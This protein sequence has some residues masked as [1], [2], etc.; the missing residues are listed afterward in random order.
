MADIQGD[1]KIGL[2]MQTKSAEQSLKS[3]RKKLH[4]GLT[5]KPLDL[6]VKNTEKTIKQLENK[7][8]KTKKKLNDLS[9]GATK[10]KQ[11]ID[12]EKE[13]DKLYAQAEK[14]KKKLDDLML[15]DIKPKSVTAM[16]RELKQVEKQIT[17]VN[18]QLD[19]AEKKESEAYDA[20]TTKYV[21]NRGLG[22]SDVAAQKAASIEFN[23]YKEAKE[24]VKALEQELNILSDKADILNSKLVE[25]QLNPQ[26]SEEF[27]KAQLEVDETNNAIDKLQLKLDKLKGN[28]QLTDEGKR[29][30]KELEEASAE[31]KKQKKHLKDIQV[32]Q[33]NVVKSEKVVA[34]GIQPITSALNKLKGMIKR[35]FVFS[36]ITSALR[37]LRNGIS[38]L[39]QKDTQLSKSLNQIKSNLVTAFA[40]IW[41]VCIP[42][43]QKLMNV[44]EVASG[45]IAKFTALITGTSLKQNQKYAQEIVDVTQTDKKTQEEIDIENQIK[46]L[47]KQNKALQKQQK[48]KEKIR[49][50]EEKA[51]QHSLASFDTISVLNQTNNDIELDALDEEIDKN[52]EI[53]DQLQEKLELLEE[54]RTG[55]DTSDRF[56]VEEVTDVGKLDFTLWE[57]LL[58]NLKQIADLFKS[59]FWK[60]FQNAD[61]TN[62]KSDILDISKSF[63]SLFSDTNVVNSAANF[64]SELIE[65]LGQIIGAVASIGV[66]IGQNLIGGIQSFLHSNLNN[67]KQDII[68]TLDVSSSILDTLGNL[69][70]AIATIFSSIGTQAGQN[71]T[72]AILSTLY[73]VGTGILTL[74]LQIGDTLLSGISQPIINNADKIKSAFEITFSAF[75]PI[76]QGVSDTVRSIFDGLSTVWKNAIAPAIN[77]VSTAFS[78][79]FGSLL[80]TFNTTIGPAFQSAFSSI[81]ASLSESFSPAISNLLSS[82]GNLASGLVQ[83]L[84]PVGSILSSL[85]DEIVSA[86]GVAVASIISLFGTILTPIINVFSTAINA[87]G[88]ILNDLGNVVKSICENNIVGAFKSAGQTIL[89]IFQGIHDTIT[90][91]LDSLV[92][93]IKNIFGNSVSSLSGYSMTAGMPNTMSLNSI[94]LQVPA[95][96]QGAVLPPNNPFLAVVSDQTQGTNIEAPA[97]LIKQMVKEANEESNVSQQPTTVREDHYYLNKTE[98]MNLT[99]KL[100]KGGEKLH[101]TELIKEV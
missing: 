58:D 70:S 63:K 35:V 55:A 97:E 15:T 94:D 52:N 53:I 98:L 28:P 49:Q 93:I 68:K 6:S 75:T 10:P 13:L 91:I 18:K 42:W 24:D 99:Y 101:G 38:Q 41:K 39:I 21:T 4:D 46:A 60:S 5:T 25:V 44:L 34:S 56:T 20:Y 80:N 86:V 26:A 37:T 100:F 30:N 33:E 57:I 12:I 62:L 69:S 47:E 61:F 78:N 27:K 67:I 16:Q 90:S 40:P 2:N 85:I 14:S 81:G 1:V 48:E 88:D 8:D 11:V 89:D 51:N 72:G 96:A 73:N 43:I 17:D 71:L 23:Q 87:I 65:V 95:L 84:S 83:L 77:V 76:I 45:Y 19:V 59:G 32:E 64:S 22:M 66:S 92:D 3:F 9:T 31:L 79:V 74:A 7:I 54:A 36:V 82:F 50:Q 29:Y